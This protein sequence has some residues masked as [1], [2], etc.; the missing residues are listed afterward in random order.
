MLKFGIN[1]CLPLA[2]VSEAGEKGLTKVKLFSMLG[3]SELFDNPASS[4]E[5]ISGRNSRDF[6]MSEILCK[7]HN[8]RFLHRPCDVRNDEPHVEV[9]EAFQAKYLGEYRRLKQVRE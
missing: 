3:K 4:H 9:A 6:F 8:S 1:F 2:G 5:K 7:N